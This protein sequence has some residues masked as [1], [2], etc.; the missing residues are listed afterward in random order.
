MSSSHSPHSSSSA[1]ELVIPTS[2]SLLPSPDGRTSFARRRLSWARLDPAQDPLSEHQPTMDE[3]TYTLDDDDDPF[4]DHHYRYPPISDPFHPQTAAADY[5]A[6]PFT[7]S[8]NPDARA[9]TT[10][11]IS[12]HRPSTLST[13]TLDDE[14]HLTANIDHP[15]MADDG[16][17]RMD[18]EHLADATTPRTRR[19]TQRYSANLSP[20]DRS[21]S[22]IKRFSRSLRRVSWRV[23]NFAGAGLDDHVLLSSGV[24][25]PADGQGRSPARDDDDDDDEA[26]RSLEPFV[27]LGKILPVRGRTLAFFGPTSRVR[28][29]M[30]NFLIFP[31]VFSF[32]FPSFL[33]VRRDC[34]TDGQNL[35][36][37]VPS[38]FTPFF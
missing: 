4:V 27:D 28:R 20:I 38:F 8:N 5:D 6:E 9:S 12:S 15:K 24:D 34:T 37:F 31:S 13:Y 35:S 18:S 19:R 25:G 32:F 23:V 29:A 1:I 33:F 16:A 10:S 7:Y 30:Y 22:A 21:G 14:A 11:L 2:P 36:S 17:W 3:Q 26:D